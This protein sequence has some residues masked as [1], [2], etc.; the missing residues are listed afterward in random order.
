MAAATKL[1]GRYI[2]HEL[3]D[4]KSHTRT[5]HVVAVLRWEKPTHDGSSDTG[6]LLTMPITQEVARQLRIGDIFAITLEPI[7]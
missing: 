3:R 6:E 5:R 2:V 1:E 4:C 7:V